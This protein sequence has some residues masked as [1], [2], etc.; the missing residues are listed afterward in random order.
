[1]SSRVVG[2]KKIKFYTNENVGSGELDLP[3]QQMHTTAYWLTI[4]QAVMAALP[5][6]R[7]RPA[8]RRGG[9]VVR[10]AAGGA[11]AAD[12][13]SPGHRH[14]DRQRR[15]ERRSAIRGSARRSA[16]PDEPR[17]FIYDNYPG[18]IGF[19]EPLF[20]MHADLLRAHARADRRLRVRARLPDVRRARSATRARSPS[21]W[22]CASSIAWRRCRCGGASARVEPPGRPVSAVSIR[23]RRSRWPSFR[24]SDDLA[25]G[26]PP[27]RHRSPAQVG[28]G[29][30]RDGR[31]PD[32]PDAEYVA[33]ISTAS[34]RSHD[35]AEVLGGAWQE[36][37]G[38]RFVV[39][40]RRYP[41]GHRH[42]DVTVAD[43]LPPSAGAWPALD[44]LART[45]CR[46][47]P[48]VRRPRNDRT[49][50]R[51]RHLR[52]P[53]RLRLVRRRLVPRPPVS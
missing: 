10:D 23:R 44:L 34:R 35:P 6:A 53:R 40:E 31:R 29:C 41:P 15:A 22:R 28:A 24:H 46:D 47:R 52:V 8:R 17:I 27:R 45:P 25:Q 11:A 3:E 20:A 19:S 5:F 4:P 39:V 37:A 12:V 38:Q 30:A 33:A 7:R 21:S 36:A 2:F 32:R 26:S 42:G 48:A 9:P 14:L 18:G 50:R 13:R 16:L 1:M 43:G 49:R 51:R